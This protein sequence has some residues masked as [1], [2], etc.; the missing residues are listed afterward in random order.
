MSK[1]KRTPNI[2]TIKNPKKSSSKESKP[3]RRKLFS[4]HFVKHK[5][6]AKSKMKKDKKDNFPSINGST[7]PTIIDLELVNPEHQNLSDNT[8]IRE[9]IFA[10]DEEP[11]FFSYDDIC[12]VNSNKESNNVPRQ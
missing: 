6:G 12:K 4:Y 5:R 11:D 3:K 9:I 8:I 7:K 1:G 10:N 2:K